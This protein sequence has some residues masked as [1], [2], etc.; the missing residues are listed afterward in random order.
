MGPSDWMY[1]AGLADDQG[2]LNTS[3]GPPLKVG[4][5]GSGRPLGIPRPRRTPDGL[6]AAGVARGSKQRSET[7]SVES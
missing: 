3:E 1:R 6:P 5:I 2:W 7:L 4:G